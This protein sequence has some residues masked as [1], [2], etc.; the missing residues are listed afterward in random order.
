M[1]C[2]DVLRAMRKEPRAVEAFFAEVTPYGQSNGHLQRA[3]DKLHAELQDASNLEYR[4]RYLVEQLAL[5][6]QGA[7]LLRSGSTTV[8]EA[9]CNSRLSGDWGR[10]FGTLPMNVDVGTIIERARPV[11]A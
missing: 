8:A 6:L 1:N 11:L 7:L 9:F 4:A 5:V 3:I 2:L 10:A